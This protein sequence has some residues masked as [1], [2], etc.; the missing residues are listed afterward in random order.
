MPSTLETLMCA[1]QL[2]MLSLSYCINCV[3]LI[4]VI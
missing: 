4:Y 1:V 2:V 3:H